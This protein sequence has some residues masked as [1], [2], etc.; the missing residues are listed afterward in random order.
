MRLS[1]NMPFSHVPYMKF[2]KLWNHKFGNYL[3]ITDVNTVTDCIDPVSPVGEDSLALSLLVAVWR[4]GG[5]LWHFISR[6][7]TKGEEQGQAL[8]SCSISMSLRLQGNNVI[9]LFSS[10]EKAEQL[11][12][13]SVNRLRGNRLSQITPDQ[14]PPCLLPL[15]HQVPRC[16][17]TSLPC[18][19]CIYLSHSETVFVFKR[20]AAP[21]FPALV[22]THIKF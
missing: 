21:K 18:L 13:S 5:A 20:L 3:E 12:S 1:S 8:K 4:W 15:A 6:A 22:S 10:M 16:S 9:C 7:R 14:L 2:E 19:V 17:Q 11:H